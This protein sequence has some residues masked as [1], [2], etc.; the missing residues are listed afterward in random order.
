MTFAT[1]IKLFGSEFGS[2]DSFFWERVGLSHFQHDFAMSFL[3]SQVRKKTREQFIQAFSS[4]I[5]FVNHSAIKILSFFRHNFFPI[6][7]AEKFVKPFHNGFINRGKFKN[8]SV[9]N[10]IKSCFSFDG[11]D[12]KTTVSI[13]VTGEISKVKFFHVHSFATVYTNIEYKSTVND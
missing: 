5:S 12:V 4:Y 2:N 3:N 13:N 10:R 9:Y 7:N 8:G 1:D 6:V 11:I